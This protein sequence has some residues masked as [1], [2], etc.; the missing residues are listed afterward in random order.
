MSRYKVYSYQV[1][2]VQAMAGASIGQG[3]G[4]EV[5]YKKVTP[6]HYTYQSV[7]GNHP[8]IFFNLSNVPWAIG[9][10]NEIY[11]SQHRRKNRDYLYPSYFG[12]EAWFGYFLNVSFQFGMFQFSTEYW[13][14]HRRVNREYSYPSFFMNLKTVPTYDWSCTTVDT[15]DKW[16]CN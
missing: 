15:T 4:S 11:W 1:Q 3:V 5:L 12:A 13:T 2:I 10:S 14:K 16:S 7:F 6:P 8:P 9:Y